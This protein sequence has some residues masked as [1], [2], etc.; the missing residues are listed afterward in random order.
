MVRWEK[1]G[2]LGK[3]APVKRGGSRVPCE[4]K[5]QCQDRFQRQ[6]VQVPSLL[7]GPEDNDVPAGPASHLR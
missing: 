1:P 2:I 4:P 7:G 5:L 3:V 6:G